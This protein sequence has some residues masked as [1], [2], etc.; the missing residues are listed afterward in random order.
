MKIST[1][2]EEEKEVAGGEAA[3]LRTLVHGPRISCSLKSA[4]I[5]A[6]CLP[7]NFLI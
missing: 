5:Q 6:S 3:N 7:K 4:V 2:E 1:R